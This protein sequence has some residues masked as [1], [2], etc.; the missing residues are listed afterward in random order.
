MARIGS[1][2]RV[3]RKSFR[4]ILLATFV[5]TAGFAAWAWFRPYQWKSPDEARCRV[6]GC[7]V[8]QDRSNYWVTIHLKLHK[9]QEHDLMQAVRLITADDRRI[10]PADTTL[11]GTDEEG[12][13]DLWFKFWLEKEDMNGALNLEIN[14]GVLS[15]RVDSGLPDLDSSGSEYFVTNQW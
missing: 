9:G 1:V 8:K 10:E 13:T 7:Q 12:T 14:E 3:K 15:I 5:V 11:G 4:I 6:L 2:G